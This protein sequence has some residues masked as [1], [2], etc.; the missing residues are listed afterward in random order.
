MSALREVPG[1]NVR[2]GG[3]SA[4]VT[5]A[6]AGIS[7][8]GAISS[9]IRSAQGK[10][11]VS[12]VR[13][14]VKALLRV[15]SLQ[16]WAKLSEI[17]LASVKAYEASMTADEAEPLTN[18]YRNI[19]L[20][21]GSEISSLLLEDNAKPL[22]GTEEELN[23]LKDLFAAHLSYIKS[24]TKPLKSHFKTFLTIK[25]HSEENIKSYEKIVGL[26]TEAEAGINSFYENKAAQI[27]AAKAFIK[28]V[29]KATAAITRAAASAA[30]AASRKAARNATVAASVASRK[31]ARNAQRL[32]PKSAASAY[33]VTNA[34][35]EA[36]MAKLAA[37]AKA[38]W[39]KAAPGGKRTRK[40]R[41]N[42]N[43]R[44]NRKSRKN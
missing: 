9:V 20:L 25:A 5:P 21:F 23:E 6:K 35:V 10:R 39:T 12:E 37:E 43:R 19:L 44:N 42:R 41:N 3:P 38:P 28:Q 8:F 27:K 26:V 33:E 1:N 36:E 40:G 15:Y 4:V 24:N 22:P 7:I 17:Q 16:D 31:A 14:T 13:E 34:D 2:M 30:A 11:P 18:I 32:A 29:G